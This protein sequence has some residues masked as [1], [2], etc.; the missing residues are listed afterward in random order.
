MNVLFDHEQLL[1]LLSSLYTLTG[2]HANILDTDGHDIRVTTDHAPFCEYVHTLPG[3]Q[4][5]C[6]E[7]DRRAVRTCASLGEEFYAYRCHLGI[8]ETVFP[9][10]SSAAQ[11]TL[12]YLIYGQ[13]LDDTPAD[14]Q[15]ENTLHT[16]T[17]M[18]D[19]ERGNLHRLFF[20]FHRYSP[21][22][23]AAYQD[24]LRALTAYICQ[25][26]MILSA[27]LTDLQ[28]LELYIDKH[29]TEKISLASLSE[30]LH[31]GRTKLC[32]LSRELSGGKTL[33]CLITQRRI[34]AAKTLLVQSDKP[35]SAIAEEVGIGDYNYFSKVFRSATGTTPSAYRK[36]FRE[37]LTGSA[38]A[39]P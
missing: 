12:A 11:E 28:R 30:H 9:I 38:D 2:I 16:L 15:W 19:E 34:E 23:L 32:Q 29:Y 20:L 37:N 6:I 10:R 14:K 24:I 13:F 27:E 4:A 7:C 21:A 3:G 36:T 22:Q 8:C 26:E 17:W 18:K 33:V 25:K 1:K 5:R 39:Q 35:V 31:I